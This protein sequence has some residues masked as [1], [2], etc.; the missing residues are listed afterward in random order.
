MARQDDSHRRARHRPRLPV[1]QAGSRRYERTTGAGRTMAADLSRVGIDGS[2]AG[3]ARHAPIPTSSAARTSRAIS[4][5]AVSL[6]IHAMSSDAISQRADPAS[7]QHQWATLED[8]VSWI[9]AAGGEAV[10]AHPGRYSLS[11][12][13]L[14]RAHRGVSG[15]RWQRDRG[16]RAEPSPRPV[17]GVGETLPRLRPEGLRRVRLSRPGRAALRPRPFAYSCRGVSPDLGRLGSGGRWRRRPLNRSGLRA[18]TD[19]RPDPWPSFSPF[20]RP[21]RSRD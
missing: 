9:R 18:L 10:I 1:L 5:N 21:T 15:P 19:V 12:E 17:R 2:F 14:A 20:T 13:K 7:F 8:A 6:R 4:L 16:R 3:A 11:D